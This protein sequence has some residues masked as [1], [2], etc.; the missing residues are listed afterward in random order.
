M[1]KRIFLLGALLVLV[2]CVTETVQKKNSEP[3]LRIMPLGDSLTEGINNNGGYRPTLYNMLK[4]DHL[5]FQFVGSQ[6]SG[7][8]SLPDKKHEGYDGRMIDEISFDVESKLQQLQPNIVL[9]SAGTKDI[10]LHHDVAGAPRRL[11]KLADEILLELPTA[12]VIVQSLPPR[13]DRLNGDVALFNRQLKALVLQKRRQ[14]R[15][16]FF[17][18]NAAL[19]SAKD[20]GPD[21][22]HPNTDGNRKL[23]ASWRSAIHRAL[24]Y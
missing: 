15:R 2:S 17:Q 24:G 22:I 14:Q 6:I 23:A 21:H 18:D 8:A 20:V 4:K 10:S 16:I 19:F 9:L 11:M 7:P 12:L 1:L 13:T 5:D 3:F